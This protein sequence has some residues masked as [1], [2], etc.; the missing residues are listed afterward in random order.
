[1]QSNGGI[2]TA[3]FMARKAVAAL[4]SGP[5]GGVM[6]ACAVAGEAE[7][8]D[9]IAID[10]GGTSYEACLVKGGR[11]NIRSFW[12]WQHRYLVG[13]PMVEMHSIGAGGGSIAYVEAGALKVGPQS[14]KADPGPICYGRG[15]GEPTVT[16]ANVVLGYVNPEALCGGE[17][18]L[19]SQ[20]VR[21]AILEKVGKP[22]GLDV[23][24]AAHGIFRIVNANMS[25]AI[26]RVS[27]ESGY[28]PR[29]FAMVVYGGNG[30]VHAACQAQELG[31]RNLLV[32]KTSPAFSALGLVIA[33]YAVDIQR[34]YITPAGRADAD[35]INTLLRELEAQAR[36]DL[37]VAGLSG[38]DIGFNRSLALCYP[39]QTFDMA[40][41]AR[42]DPD[43]CMGP[44][45]LS[46]TVAAF[47]DLHEETHTY[48]ARDEEPVLRSVR[49]QAVGRTP[50]PALQRLA[51]TRRT[52]EQALRSRRPAWFDG[53]F[54]DTPVYDGDRIG[55]GHTIEGPAI[56]EERFTTI[57]VQPGHVAQVDERGNYAITLPG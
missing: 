54:V 40:V 44:A 28:D 25:N 23:V 4:G 7:T 14:A 41:P 56:V 24:E 16:D 18:K 55:C 13:L 36:A 43:G 27:C 49:V 34:S 32:P 50:K 39:G 48:A 35:R 8:P 33:D 22:L 46:A 51:P 53:A 10:M 1:M 12:N 37:G 47:H 26:R 15:G 6:G 9:F 31:V 30:P 57:V 42:L 2:M 29:D 21:E 5:T 19:T 45:E 11:P 52:L 20:G 17:F 3:S 38:G